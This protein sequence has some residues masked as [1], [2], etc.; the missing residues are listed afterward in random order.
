MTLEIILKNKK[1]TNK[2]SNLKV[3]PNISETQSITP[4][5]ET[6]LVSLQTGYNYKATGVK[7][8]EKLNK[9]KNKI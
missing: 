2:Q 5:S 6:A 1:A 8:K 4:L 7:N 9:I 3:V